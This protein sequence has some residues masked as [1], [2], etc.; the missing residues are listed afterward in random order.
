[1]IGDVVV[2]Q[3]P[4]HIRL[5]MTPWTVAYQAS[6]SLSVSQNLP[7]FVFHSAFSSSDA[8]FFFTLNL[9]QHQGLFQWVVCSHQMTKILELSA[10]AS[11]LPVNIQGWPPLR[12]TSL[13]SLLSKG[14]LGIFC[15]T[16]VWRHQFF[17]IAFFMVQLSQLYVTTGKTIVLTTWAFVG[18]IMSLLFNILSIFVIVFLPRGNCPLISWLQSLYAVILEPKKRK[19][20]TTIFPFYLPCSNGTR[21]HDLRFFFFFNILS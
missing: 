17:D 8:L 19:S 10:S 13:I 12:L 21:C 18:R 3:S 11:V 2:V 6:L 9:S 20:V 4:S 5:F 14:L 16:T 15:S 7:K 1:M